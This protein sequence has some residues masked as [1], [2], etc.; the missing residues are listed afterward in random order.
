MEVIEGIMS[1][2]SVRKFV[3]K[4]IEKE[5]IDII[6]E[7]GH[8]APS[9]GNMQ[10]W[11]FIVVRDAK[12]KD[13]LYNATWNQPWIRVADTLIIVAANPFDSW[14]HVRKGDVGGD[15]KNVY[16]LD[17][18]AAIENMLLAAHSLNLGAV[19]VGSMNKLL[20]FEV[21]GEHKKER[22]LEIISII[23]LGYPDAKKLGKR[24][25]RKNKKDIFFSE[26]YGNIW[27]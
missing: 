23:A 16:P 1:R 6:L 2:H 3:K 7:A 10:P 22:N 4:K 24:T 21:I 18:G 17:I 5:K 12:S 14:E 19:W 15:W 20:V 8:R 11:R 13:K 25:S 27:R 26:K 9:A